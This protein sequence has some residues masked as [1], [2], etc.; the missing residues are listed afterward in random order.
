GAGSR[1]CALSIAGVRRNSSVRG[2]QHGGVPA[3]Q[4]HGAVPLER[5]VHGIAAL[6]ASP[7][8][9]LAL[10]LDG[11]VVGKD[12]RVSGPVRTAVATA[13]ATGV[14]VPIATGR[15]FRSTLPFARQLNLRDPL[16]C[17]QGAL[18]QHPLT[19][20]VMHHTPMSGALAA[21]AIA[22]LH[23]AG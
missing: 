6:M 14:C 3:R 18:I 7:Y 10:D 16:I 20:A 8:R 22:L 21:E 1:A 12:L 5:G 23:A 11:T 13:Q 9:L 2:E 19:E 4:H 17:H 15:M